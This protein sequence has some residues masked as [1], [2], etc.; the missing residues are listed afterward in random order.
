AVLQAEGNNVDF[1]EL[2]GDQPPEPGTRVAVI[3]S[4]VALEGTLSDGI[5]SAHR[6][7]ESGPWIQLTAPISP[8]SSGSPIINFDG[9]VI[10]IATLNINS[11]GRYQ[12]LNFA[13][14]VSEIRKLV[15]AIHDSVK[16]F[17]AAADD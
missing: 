3:G 4:P 10:G 1:L 12:S 15:D 16:T 17:I 2:A 9:K 14:P 6:T 13:R 5:I 7:D 8:G 11:E